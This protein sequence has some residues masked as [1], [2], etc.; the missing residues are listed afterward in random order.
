MWKARR[1]KTHSFLTSFTFSDTQAAAPKQTYQI[2]CPLLRKHSDEPQLSSVFSSLQYWKCYIHR[3]S[4]ATYFPSVSVWGGSRARL[5]NRKISNR[6][7]A[8]NNQLSF[9]ALYEVAYSTSTKANKT[10]IF[11]KKKKIKRNKRSLKIS[12]V[13][14]KKEI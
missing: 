2:V 9:S 13:F 4:S 8:R 3:C 11:K 7:S 10:R 6:L 12:T 1:H 14:H 5:E